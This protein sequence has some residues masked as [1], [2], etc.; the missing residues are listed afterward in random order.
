MSSRG[1]GTPGRV[2]VPYWPTGDLW[3]ILIAICRGEEYHVRA[4]VH[5]SLDL[6]GVVQVLLG[7]AVWHSTGKTVVPRRSSLRH[8]ARKCTRTGRNAF[9]LLDI[10]DVPHSSIE[11]I[12]V[13][14]ATMDRDA[15]MV[16]R[17]PYS[18][19]YQRLG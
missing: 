11:E 17:S 6:S 1:L 9:S 2:L 19:F 5:Q 16:N 3:T 15:S 14:L 8:V 18:S 13:L 12:P 7:S 4:A 10:K